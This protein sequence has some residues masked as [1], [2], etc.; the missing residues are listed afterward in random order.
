MNTCHAL[1]VLEGSTDVTLIRTC[2]GTVHGAEE[3]GPL[4]VQFPPGQER[5]VQRRKV[6][7]GSRI[8]GLFDAFGKENAAKA[9]QELVRLWRRGMFPNLRLLALVVDLDDGVP[10]ALHHG[11]LQRMEQ[12]ARSEGLA[13][14]LLEEQPAW[15]DLGELKVTQVL[16]PKYWLAILRLVPVLRTPLRITFFSFSGGSVIAIHRGLRG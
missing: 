1:F 2:L 13:L 7:I 11:F 14:S 3:I 16:V 4:H 10:E 12:L 8:V 9:H 15:A 6:Q 5:P